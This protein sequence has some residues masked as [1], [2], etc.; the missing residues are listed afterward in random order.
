M[1][2]GEGLMEEYTNS[3]VVCVGEFQPVGFKVAVILL[4]NSLV[5]D[6]FLDAVGDGVSDFVSVESISSPSDGI[7]AAVANERALDAVADIECAFV[8]ILFNQVV[9]NVCTPVTDN[10]GVVWDTGSLDCGR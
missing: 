6:D 8:D 1:Y 4:A 2:V 3:E 7:N 5:L 10:G 9:M